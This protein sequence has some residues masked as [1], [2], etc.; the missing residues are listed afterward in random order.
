MNS[1]FRQAIERHF[2]R[3]HGAAVGLV[4]FSYDRECETS[5]DRAFE[6]R[7]YT[8]DWGLIAEYRNSEAIQFLDHLL[9]S[10]EPDSE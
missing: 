5:S 2:A 1:L 8:A 6:I 10:E 4:I 7:V 3:T 9:D